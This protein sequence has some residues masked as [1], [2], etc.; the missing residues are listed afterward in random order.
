M[1]GPSGWVISHV[2]WAMPKY[3]EATL[4]AETIRSDRQEE[5]LDP[6]R[7]YVAIC[8]PSGSGKSSLLNALRGLPN[9]DPDAAM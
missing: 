2:R 9:G 6:D 3:S 1:I 5:G 7:A 4:T 8:G